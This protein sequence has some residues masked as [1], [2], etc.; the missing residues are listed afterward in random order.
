MTKR[1]AGKTLEEWQEFAR[2]DD[3]LDKMVP[4]DLRQ[5]V[6][7]AVTA[8]LQRE[9]LQVNCEAQ[10]ERDRVGSRPIHPRVRRVIRLQTLEEVREASLLPKYAGLGLKQLIE[11][12]KRE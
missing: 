4:S 10:E 7:E 6:A 3:C 11:D 2:R 5:L 8:N 9:L 12:L 1:I